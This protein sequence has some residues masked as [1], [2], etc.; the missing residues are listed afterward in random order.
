MEE[1]CEGKESLRGPLTFQFHLLPRWQNLQWPW[2]KIGEFS[3]II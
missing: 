2:L 1:A 3:Q